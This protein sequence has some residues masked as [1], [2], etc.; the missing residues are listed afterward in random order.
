[1]ISND[2]VPAGAEMGYRMESRLPTP[3]A[4]PVDAALLFGRFAAVIALLPNG[5]RKI[6]TFEATARGMGGEVQMID[7]RVFPDQTPLFYFPVPELF[8]AASTTFDLLG[9]A[10]V[11]IGW[12]T[13]QVAL[14]LALYVLLAMTIYHSDIR[15]M[16]DAMQ[17]L[18]NLPFLGALVML[19]AVGGGHW[20]I[21]GLLAR[22]AEPT[23]RG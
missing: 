9:A 18:R 19:A 20:S 14:A 10:L 3:A 23:R 12:R 16:Q 5:A 21:D 7:G 11:L 6:A 2:R 15:H 13:R 4:F 17:I 22:N 8:L 1:L